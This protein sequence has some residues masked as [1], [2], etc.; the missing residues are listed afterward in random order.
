MK[1]YLL[2]FALFVQSFLCFAQTELIRIDQNK[3]VYGRYASIGIITIRVDESNKALMSTKLYDRNK[4]VLSEYMMG[5]KLLLP[6][7]VEAD[8]FL[9]TIAFELSDTLS[10]DDFLI[11][12]KVL[13]EK[14]MFLYHAGQD[15]AGYSKALCFYSKNKEAVR[16]YSNA[17]YKYDSEYYYAALEDYLKLRNLC[18]LSNLATL[19]LADCYLSEG[20]YS[21][22]IKY[23]HSAEKYVDGYLN[24]SDKVK[25][26]FNANKT[27]EGLIYYNLGFAY[28]KLNKINEAIKYYQKSALEYKYNDA[29]WSDINVKLAFCYDDLGNVF[30]AINILV[31][32]IN[33]YLEVNKKEVHQCWDNNYKD[34]DLG[35]LLYW[36]YVY[37]EKN[38]SYNCEP[39]LKAAAKWGCRYAIEKCENDAINYKTKVEVNIE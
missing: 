31:N 19:D 17:K 20:D 37:K 6:V 35:R 26:V 34:E 5:G 11:G 27:Y 4:D 12:E 39:I 18:P 21:N 23:L 32:S 16:L 9:G 15:K 33:T 2:L 3:S 29:M 14:N 24:S 36:L 22:A 25:I 8:K 30:R 10:N 1:R 28:Y 13:N 38:V 7:W